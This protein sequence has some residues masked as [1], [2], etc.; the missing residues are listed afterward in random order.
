[1]NPENTAFENLA[2]NP[3]N[4]ETVL[5]IGVVDL[6]ENL[7]KEF[8]ADLDTKYFFPE[9]LPDHFQNTNN[10]DFSILHLNH[11][12]FAKTFR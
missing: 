7:F 8:L 9:V 5:L 6:D 3:V 12:N 11:L 10:K 4:L 2:F 1:M